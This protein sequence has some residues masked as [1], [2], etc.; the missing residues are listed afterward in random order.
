M[1]IFESNGIYGN[2]ETQPVPLPA[3]AVG[4]DTGE[5]V[6]FP[7][8]IVGED[9]TEPVAMPAGALIA[10]NTN[11][12]TPDEE[13]VGHLKTSGTSET[14]FSG[15][16]ADTKLLC[17]ITLSPGNY[18]IVC[19]VDAYAVTTVPT[20]TEVTMISSL[21]TVPALFTV[22]PNFACQ[23]TAIHSTG[24][25]SFFVSKKITVETTFY[26]N[27]KVDTTAANYGFQAKISAERRH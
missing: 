4:G 21:D 11:G 18:L 27:V 7:N 8:G 12:T 19:N 24:A 22:F 26:L 5:P 6:P 16:A 1:T 17:S 13:F 9:D 15:G 3:G 23:K 2:T 25:H 20:G 10:G 14:I